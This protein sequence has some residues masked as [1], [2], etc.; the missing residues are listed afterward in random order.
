[1]TGERRT[2][3]PYIPSSEP[4]MRRAM[5]RTIGA[6]SVD[7]LYAD[8]PADL[9]LDRPLELPAPLASELELRRHIAALLSRNTSTTDAL[10]FLGAGCYPHFVPAVCDEV[11]GR[12][13]FLTA[14]GGQPYEDH[15]RFQALFEYSSMLGELLEMD[16]VSVPT[17]DG[18]QAAATA[19]RM[20]GRITGRQVAL[21]PATTN[22]Q[23]ASVI[24][25]YLE[26]A[27]EV[28]P[29]AYDRR[30]G[31]LDLEDLRSKLSGAT[32]AVLVE[33]PTYLGLIEAQV[34]E[35]VR[36]AHRSGALAIAC[37]DPSSLG[38]L[39]APGAYGADIACGDLQPLGMHMFF[40]GG[41]GGFIATPDEERF[42]A[43][44][45]SRLF[46]LTHTTVEGEYGFGDVAWARTSFH[47]REEGK[48][49][50][51]TA[52]ALWG[53]TA[54]VYLALMGPQGM[55][56]LGETR[57]RL[58][59]YAAGEL[60]TLPGVRA[61][62]FTGIPFQE[63][64][65]DFSGTRRTV[66]EINAGLLEHGIFGG[67]DLSADFPELGQAALYCVTETHTRTDVDR[68]TAT[69]REVLA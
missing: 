13:E 60:A 37:V 6:R 29:V 19:L 26:G 7:E 44:Y 28:A 55:A 25:N 36:L 46:G 34:R 22:P 23:R 1:M 45:P 54:G 39:E 9:R 69:L 66:A 27:L 41:Q 42:V 3:H 57:M 11:N 4:Q 52:A 16:V 21:V 24:A 2:M 20:A 15:G 10:S 68:L 67:V 40:G 12:S 53:I 63:F 30:T 31:L 17:F 62:R 14:Y 59:R 51:G 47:G 56:Q 48:E 61:P 33:N 18:A 5:L 35:V 58:T 50:V 65:A 49:Y 43:E 8:I 32:A 64:V 38:V